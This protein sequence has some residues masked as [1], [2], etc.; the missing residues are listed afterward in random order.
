M[1]LDLTKIWDLT[2]GDPEICVAIIDGTA[3]LQHSCFKNA[4]VSQV[5]MYNEE[6]SDTSK[7]GTQVSSIILG[8]HH[9]EIKGIAPSVTGVIIPIYFEEETGVIIPASQLDLARAIN[10]AIEQGAHII[11]ISGG[12]F[13]DT[14]EPEGLLASALKQC[15]ENNILIVAAVGNDGCRCL[16]IPAASP[17]VLAVGAMDNTGRPMTFSN[18][19]K[20]YQMNGIL[21][22][23]MQISG[24]TPGN[25]ITKSTGTSYAAPFVTGVAAL[26]L[27]LQKAQ[28]KSINPLAVK[29]ALLKTA[30]PCPK[31]G[32][33]DCIKFLS[34][35]LNIDAALIELFGDTEVQP[36][37]LVIFDSTNSDSAIKKPE[38]LSFNHIKNTFTMDNLIEANQKGNQKEVTQV[39]PSGIDTSKL[40]EFNTS[41]QQDILPQ[42]LEKS[43]IN[44]N[45][46]PLLEEQSTNLSPSSLIP[47]ALTPSAINPSDCGCGGKKQ[48]KKKKTESSGGGSKKHQQVYALGT[49]SYNF[50]SETRRDGF[51]QSTG[52][53]VHDT[54]FML[55]YLKENPYAS[56]DLTW[57]LNQ[58]LTPIYAIHPVG[59]F[60]AYTFKILL[61]FLQD[62]LENG[63]ERVSIPGI[64]GGKTSLL[65]GQTIPV[66]F[67][68]VRSMASW[69]TKALVDSLD[70]EEKDSAYQE[71]LSN[72]LE[73]VYYELRNFGI[74]P[75]DRAINYS[76]TNAFQAGSVFQKAIEQGMELSGITAE[77]SP[78]GR[79]GT[80]TY[81]VKLTFFDP[82]N[83]FEKARKVFR[84]SVD[85]SD[86]VPVSVGT[87]RSWSVY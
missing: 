29:E 51:T 9:S 85:V 22:P 66:I 24:A 10:K 3:D 32:E 82:S 30:T 79:P 12:E 11:N 73:R 39:A 41:E 34:G 46:E 16:H 5:S 83:R 84:W 33:M 20:A 63:V 56:T 55:K 15:D 74:T 13:N 21:A 71:R 49:L 35:S 27:S 68:N 48:D 65:S 37:D 54:A 69:S 42:E 36:A 1:P 26:L 43:G 70:I 52:G 4:K 23:G 76:A 2:K 45:Q 25:G 60:A 31:D 17:S 14:G 72:F 18:F 57:T 87:V 75:S 58:E 38:T 78:I 40:L 77:K 8:Q 59:P 86:V 64:I 7:H 19:G 80:D 50:V 81:D 6:N 61:D 53:N 44:N 47:P 62:Q 67:P 28:G